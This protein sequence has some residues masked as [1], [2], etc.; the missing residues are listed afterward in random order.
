MDTFS[1]SFEACLAHFAQRLPPHGSKIS[2]FARRNLCEFVGASDR[3]AARWIYGKKKPKAI[4][5]IKMRF[6]LA[7][8]GYD[9][10]ELTSLKNDHQ[11]CYKVAELIAFGIFSVT[12]IR[13]QI[14]LRYDY[15]L[16][17][18]AHGTVTNLGPAKA[19][20]VEELWKKN[21]T[22]LEESRLRWE[23]KLNTSAD[24]GGNGRVLAHAEVPVTP[25][26][27]C[28]V[29]AFGERESLMKTLA[30][31]I[32]AL[33]EL[34]ERVASDEFTPEERRTLRDLTGG[35]GIFRAANALNRLCGEKAREALSPSVRSPV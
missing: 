19:A 17:R 24:E 14:G 4:E 3:T 12:N 32:L 22:V 20:I 10:S 8:I 26:G 28:L 5:L 35:K 7:M 9:V 11:I 1:G 21:Q 33:N 23:K 16:L 13:E 6:Y 27:S 30:Y 31:Q 29:S 34:A 25:A 15:D 2:S 18:A